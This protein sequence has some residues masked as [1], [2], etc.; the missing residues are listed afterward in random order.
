MKEA[1]AQEQKYLRELGVYEKVDERAAVAK[2][3]TPIEPMQI[4][5]RIVVREFRSGD[6]P[7][8]YAGTLPL[9]ALKSIISIAASHGP[10]YAL[11]HTPQSSWQPH[12]HTNNS[13]SSYAF[14]R[15]VFK[16]SNEL[17]ANM[18][19]IV[20]PLEVHAPSERVHILLERA[21]LAVVHLVQY[22]IVPIR[23]A[24]PRPVDEIL[25]GHDDTS[26]PTTQRRCL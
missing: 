25:S 8:L 21:L 14:R 24:L 26:R 19:V 1:R 13:G 5:S 18:M 7:D 2:Y 20:E 11:M 16:R 17:A 10:E 6:G 3:V 4:R 12:T 23:I 9:E 15:Y 22:G